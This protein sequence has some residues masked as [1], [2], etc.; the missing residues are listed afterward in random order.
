MTAARATSAERPSGHLPPPSSS[1]GPVAW[2]RKNLFG[3]LLD[4]ILTI[5]LGL[6]LIWVALRLIWRWQFERKP[7]EARPPFSPRR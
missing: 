1:V 4:G 7:V 6:I 2:L 3:S 5:G